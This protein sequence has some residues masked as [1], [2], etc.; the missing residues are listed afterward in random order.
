MGGLI[1]K[2]RKTDLENEFEYFANSTIQKSLKASA[3]EIYKKK[4]VEI[5]WRPGGHLYAYVLFP[6]ISQAEEARFQMR[7]KRLPGSSSERLRID[8]VD[9]KKFIKQSYMHSRS[10]RPHTPLTP[11]PHEYISQKRS[12]SSS[13]EK[14]RS[15]PKRTDHEFSSR[16][17]EEIKSNSHCLTENDNQHDHFRKFETSSQIDR[18]S[19]VKPFDLYPSETSFAK[20]Q[21]NSNATKRSL[22]RSESK[23]PVNFK[24]ITNLG[25]EDNRRVIGLS[26]PPRKIIENYVPC[27]DQINTSNSKYNE[28]KSVT[29]LIESP[30]SLRLINKSKPSDSISLLS[31]SKLENIIITKT[32]NT[33]LVNTVSDLLHTTQLDQFKTEIKLN[34][35]SALTAELEMVEKNQTE[36]V[37]MHSIHLNEQKLTTSSQDQNHLISHWNTDNQIQKESYNPPKEIKSLKQ[38]EIKNS[39][40]ETK[41]KEIDDSFQDRSSYDE[42]SS[43]RSSQKE[44]HH[45]NNVENTECNEPET[46]ESSSPNSNVQKRKQNDHN[47]EKASY[48]KSTTS[49]SCTFNSSKLINETQINKRLLNNNLK[50]IDLIS[51]LIE[52]SWSGIF[53]LKKHIFP[54]KFYLIGGSKEFAEQ[55]LPQQNQQ[56]SSLHNCL[57]ISQRLRLD[58]SKLDELEK[59]L[60]EVNHHLNKADMHTFSVLV[61]VPSDQ[62]N[63][64]LADNQYHQRSLHNLISYLDQKNAAGVIPLPDDDKPNSMMHAFTP[65]CSLSNKL[66]NQ[67]FPHIKRVVNAN[68]LANNDFIIII[69]FK[70]N[71][72]NNNINGKVCI[73]NTI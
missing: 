24:Q 50:S 11:P 57:R 19:K 43:V 61:S 63:S 45:R 60:F 7:G 13:I 69:I 8:Y 38:N 30:S 55:I 10:S 70:Q 29:P 4:L 1:E 35:S 21:L 34:A 36:Y 26:S 71:L 20:S 44:R 31:C 28:D 48:K 59:K 18:N 65:N 54:T 68:I 52:N 33:R 3:H 73:S 49:L 67:L 66:V 5:D 64:Q 25:S 16:Q 72:N 14:K 12:R 62:L 39:T 40:V 37:T 27:E 46:Y 2:S 41:S 47:E 56:Q 53:T 51:T 42:L 58:E 15:I 22:T 6:T 9:P 32:E 17:I 23:S